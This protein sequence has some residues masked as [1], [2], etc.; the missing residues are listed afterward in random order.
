M[1]NSGQLRCVEVS[2]FNYFCLQCI[3]FVYTFELLSFE[4]WFAANTQGKSHN[5]HSS[6]KQKFDWED[7][8]K[9]E[10]QLTPDEILIRD[11]FHSYC[12]EKLM[13]RIT[14]ANRNESKLPIFVTSKVVA[15]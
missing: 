6:T 9:L 2:L 5:L 13:P 1:Q 14:L 7:A 4:R 3:G 8:F 10:D 11:Q 12:Q 15:A